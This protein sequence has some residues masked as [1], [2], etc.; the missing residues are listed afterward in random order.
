[1]IENQQ[2]TFYGIDLTKLIFIANNKYHLWL[3]V[4]KYI[5]KHSNMKYKKYIITTDKNFNLIEQVYQEF[6]D[7]EP[8]DMSN[9]KYLMDILYGN[10]Y[11]EN[12]CSKSI[13][14]DNFI[15]EVLNDFFNNEF[16]IPVLIRS[17]VCEIT[18]AI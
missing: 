8:Y 1:M 10:C 14:M 13:T 16:L 17:C 9:Y 2:G 7:N 12:L 5:M 11:T 4:Y 6:Y 18:I 15:D 3:I